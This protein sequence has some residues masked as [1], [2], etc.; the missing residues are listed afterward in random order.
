[1]KPIVK[2][3]V[4]K[5]KDKLIWMRLPN[6]LNERFDH[7]C[8]R[9]ICG[10]STLTRMAVVRLVEE[11]EAKERALAEYKIKEVGK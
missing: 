4:I 1:M 2:K 3:K 7:Q 9:L 8:K 11:E 10:N 6:A 5:K